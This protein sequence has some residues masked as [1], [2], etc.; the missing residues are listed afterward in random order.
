V[1]ESS[2]QLELMQQN[3]VTNTELIQNMFAT[4]EQQVAAAE[5]RAQNAEQRA[6]D[7][8]QN[9]Q[10]MAQWSRH[11]PVPAL[12][13]REQSM[14]AAEDHAPNTER[15]DAGST[16][17]LPDQEMGDPTAEA[18]DNR[19]NPLT[20]EL[21]EQRPEDGG[22]SDKGEEQIPAVQDTHMPNSS[23]VSEKGHTTTTERHVPNTGRQIDTGVDESMKDA[24]TP[25]QV[26]RRDPI[27]AEQSNQQSDGKDHRNRNQ[28]GSCDRREQIQME[29]PS[30]EKRASSE[31]KW[32][33]KGRDGDKTMKDK[34]IE[35][36]EE[37]TTAIQEDL[38]AP[39]RS[40]PRSGT[41][42]HS[43]KN[44]RVSF[45][46]SRRMQA[47]YLSAKEWARSKGKQREED[48]D[49]GDE[50]DDDQV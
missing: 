47:E 44:W 24:T 34:E 7:A 11:I 15:Q 35:E 49:G 40:K 14:P 23:L 36:E 25:T 33:E 6:A 9:V 22:R 26:S 2:R 31:G 18:Q 37:E 50:P 39:E 21:P 10:N 8:E 32:G 46:R 43:N 4:L 48:R 45:D 30:V 27:V 19:D 17:T 13:T 3:F 16:V 41:R 20:R 5:E 1:R 38:T 12:V 42:G 28:K 29:Q